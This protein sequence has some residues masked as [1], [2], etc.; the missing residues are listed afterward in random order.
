LAWACP[1]EKVSQG[2]VCEFVSPA[3]VAALAKASRTVGGPDLKYGGFAPDITFE[4]AEMILSQARVRLPKA[5]VVVL[6]DANQDL[7]KVL[8]QLDIRT[9]MFLMKKQ[10]GASVQC[11]NLGEILALFKK[12]LKEAFPTADSSI[13]DDLWRPRVGPV[14][15]TGMAKTTVKQEATDAIELATVSADGSLATGRALLRAQGYDL[16]CIVAMVE[17][18]TSDM[19]RVIRIEDNAVLL[20]SLDAPVVQKETSVQDFLAKGWRLADEKKRVETMGDWFRSRVF[21]TGIG[22]QML[23]KGQVIGALGVLAGLC[24]K[25]SP[26]NDLL[27][28]HTKP[29]TKVVTA[30]ACDVGRLVLVPETL[31]IKANEVEPGALAAT[32]VGG[33]GPDGTLEVQLQ[34]GGKFRYSLAPMTSAKCMAPLWFVKASA[35]AEE[36]NVEWA[37]YDVHSITAADFRPGACGT[38]PKDPL[39]AKRLTKKTQ[40][41]PTPEEDAFSEVV[42][43]PVLINTCSLEAGQEIVVYRAPEAKKKRQTEAITYAALAKRGKKS[44]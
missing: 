26:L 17:E 34:N 10:E 13:F 19:H 8:V 22:E 39:P 44:E 15:P 7:L 2:G 23:Q 9:A 1:Q 25:A 14:K 20:E 18:A 43:V 41:G 11:K 12:E 5:K 3:E 16:G 24:E 32:F 29:R 36:C 35:V 42:R 37:T 33:F 38:T 40:Q 31:N 21:N 27:V 6:P 30:K 4:D 28:I